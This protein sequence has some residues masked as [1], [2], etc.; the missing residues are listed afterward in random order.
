MSGIRNTLHK[1]RLDAFKQWL[2]ENNIATRPG[3]G[4]WQ[5]LQVQTQGAGWQCIFERVNMAEH[6]SV[7][8]KLLPLVRQFISETKLANKLCKLCGSSQFN[9]HHEGINQKDL[10]DVHYWQIRALKAECAEAVEQEVAR[11]RS[12]G[13]TK[14][15]LARN[16]QE[17][18]FNVPS[19]TLSE[20]LLHSRL[21]K[22][23]RHWQTQQTQQAQQTF[24][25]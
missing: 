20:S 15:R 17:F 2:L 6:L 4:D 23:H 13:W 14:A 18:F 21:V 5:V 25:F 8:E 9:L 7:N 10:C 19:N 12:L 24:F 22:E 1:S 3:K 11:L 16:S